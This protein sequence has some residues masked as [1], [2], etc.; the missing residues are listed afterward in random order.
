MSERLF[1]AGLLDF[2][3]ANIGTHALKKS[4]DFLRVDAALGQFHRKR[5]VSTA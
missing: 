4:L 2:P 3:H 1:V 5:V